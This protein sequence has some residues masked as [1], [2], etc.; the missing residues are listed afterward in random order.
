MSTETAKPKLE[1]PFGAMPE[2]APEPGS[3][4]RIEHAD[5]GL[6][7]LVL[8]PPH[9]K[10]AVLD[11]ALMRDLDLALDEIENDPTVR[12]LVIT[13]RE[14]LS[15]AAGADVKAIEAVETVEQALE[16]VR[17]GQRT[18]DRIALLSRHGGGGLV[19]VAAVGGPVPGG[20][21]ELA[22]ACDRIVCADDPKTRVGLP[23]VKLGIY[24]GWGGTQ[25]LPR[26]IGIPRA[27]GAILSGR[28]YR[29]RAAKKLGLVDRLTHPEY[30]VR[31]ASDIALDRL[32]CPRRERGLW[33]YLID[34]NP[35]ARDFVKRQAEKT[36]R[37]QTRGHYPAP[38][39]ALELVVRA[40]GI[41]LPAGLE[42][43][44]RGVAPLIAGPVAKSLVGLFGLSEDAKKLGLLPSGEKPARIGRA[45]VIGGGVMGGAIASLLA[46]KHVDTRIRD[47]DA[48]ALA[49]AVGAH[50]AQIQ[51]LEKRRSIDKHEAMAAIDRLE[52]TTAG[53]GFGRCDLVVEAVAERL[54]V[55]QAVFGELAR[56]LADDAILATNTSSLSVTQ[57]AEGIPHPERVVGMHVINPVR[58]MPLVEIVRGEATSDE[59]VAR[60]AR[61]A[62]DLGKTP[63]VVKD[64]AGFLVNRLLGPYLDEALRLWEG[65]AD[66]EA[67]DRALLD[68]GMPMG[69]F[70]LIDEVGLDI[71]AHAAESLEEAYGVRMQKST[72]LAALVEAGELGKKTLRGVFLYEE[73]KGRPRKTGRNPRL[74][75]PVGG[76]RH[77]SSL[78]PKDLVDRCVLAMVNEAAR[79][80]AEGVVAGP[81]VLD[82]ATVFGMGFA[83]FRGGLWRFA[84]SLGRDELRGRLEELA[85]SPGVKDRPGGPERFT[86]AGELE[87]G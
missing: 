75:R 84:T 3:C 28:L 30:L 78:F 12:G 58:R 54:E 7:R 31:V 87:L 37:R 17:F 26:R 63:V 38:L 51:K 73:K 72:S 24:P 10:L 48:G 60:T 47:L 55:K 32:E 36:V 80:L 1:L 13:G 79:C 18:F 57:I 65:G 20:A 15:F 8:A 40:P 43:E 66:P 56:E 19:T 39:K 33:R 42:E 14:P 85:Q 76:P 46:E 41:P 59:V 52:A 74:A 61:L 5:D 64:V 4:I 6:V 68:F 16:L 44:A 49:Q 11:L 83:P 70:E 34:L 25:R 86:P 82:L 62:L 21:Y 71:A 2:D 9:R 29:A 67:V 53:A 23:E 50:R 27:L 81:G 45:G 69:P 77:D 22:L 35:L